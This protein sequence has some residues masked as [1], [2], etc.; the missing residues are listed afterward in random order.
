MK[1]IIVVILLACIMISLTGCTLQK[2][3]THTIMSH[4]SCKTF[5][6]TNISSF[7]NILFSTLMHQSYFEPVN[8]AS[9]ADFILYCNIHPIKTNQDK[10]NIMQNIT[11][12]VMFSLYKKG[13]SKSIIT[14]QKI[15]SSINLSVSEISQSQYNSIAIALFDKITKEIAQECN[16]IIKINQ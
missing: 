8:D 16:K 9:I 6:T 10:N 5:P 15:S 4:I 7:S 3:S 12:S 14:E 13:E 11:L 2:Y 1:K